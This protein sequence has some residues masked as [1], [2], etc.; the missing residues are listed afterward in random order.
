MLDQTVN[1]PSPVGRALP[2]PPTWMQSLPNHSLIT[3]TLILHVLL[4]PILTVSP[5]L[6]GA[7]SAA[8]I[9]YGLYLAG[10]SPRIERAI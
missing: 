6:V 9:L 8:T 3:G 5:V 2:A 10:F 4:G 1:T 7:H